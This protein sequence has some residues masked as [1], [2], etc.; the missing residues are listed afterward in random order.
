MAVIRLA[1]AAPVTS[2]PTSFMPIASLFRSAPR[3]W[4]SLSAVLLASVAAAFAQSPSAVDGFDPNVDGNVYGVAL[5]PDGKLILAG[6]FSRVRPKGA[7]TGVRNN[8]ARLNLDGSLDASF[9]PN[10]NGTVRT[11]VLQT[12]GQILIG[13]DFTS[14]QPNG[15]ASATTRNRVARLN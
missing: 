14:L 9:N 1:Q 15:A 11:I 2:Y 12:N 13:G 7:D 10:A 3:L 8:L 5:Q 4:R 6:Q